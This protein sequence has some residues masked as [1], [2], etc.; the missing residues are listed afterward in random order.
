MGVFSCQLN[1]EILLEG[2]VKIYGVV[3]EVRDINDNAPYFQED[4]LEIKMSENAVTGL[5]FPLPHAWDLDFR[6]NALQRYRLSSNTHF[7]LDVQSGADDNKY[8]ELVLECALDREQKA[9]HHLV[10][11]ASYGGD[12]VHRNRTRIQVMVV[13]VNNTPVFAQPEYHV[14][15]PENVA[16]GTKLLLV[17]ATDPDEGATAEVM[18]SFLYVDKKAAQVQVFKVDANLG[19]V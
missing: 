9:V 13:D 15:V 14:S 11:T 1:L 3:A 10:L 12:P 5:R 17:S 16:I 4:E 6:K 18:Y 2:K 19:R 8:P 7:S